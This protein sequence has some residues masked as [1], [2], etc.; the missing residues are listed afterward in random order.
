MYFTNCGCGERFTAVF[1]IVYILL[2]RK[3][4]AAIMGSTPGTCV[5]IVRFIFSA[6]RSGTIELED[7][8]RPRSKE[9]AP[10]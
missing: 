6:A 7:S 2:R 1:N 3:L 10:K 4:G 5:D 9:V 8:Q